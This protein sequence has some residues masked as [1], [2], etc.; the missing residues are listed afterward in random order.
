MAGRTWMTLPAAALVVAGATMLVT[1]AGATESSSMVVTG[2][3]TFTGSA[4][5]PEPIDMS[6]DGYCV[7]QHTTPVMD[8][9]VRIDDSGGLAGVLVYVSNAPSGAGPAA[10]DETLL[11]QVGCIYTPGAVAVR[12][13]Q[14]LVV[15]N[16]DQT[17]HNVRVTPTLNRGFNLGQPMRGIESRRSF[18]QP[19]VGI[20]V[21]CDIHGWMHATL[22]V[23]DHGFHT[24]TGPDGSFE[25]PDL[26]AGDWVVE[27]WHPTLGTVS[28]Q[29]AGGGAAA[30]E[31]EFGG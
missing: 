23:I 10:G 31:L 12:V 7:D 18:D 21:R 22:H 9:S 24:I 28:S 11:D 4:P 2:R 6:A 15:R 14:T 26:P 19:E 30:I 5:A 27:A 20:P 3:V 29:I 25:L 8:A 13:G 17:L 16:S 1:A